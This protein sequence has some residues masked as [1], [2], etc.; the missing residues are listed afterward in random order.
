[1]VGGA[2]IAGL[3][4]KE[5]AFHVVW[6]R[7]GWECRSES[8]ALSATSELQALEILEHFSAGPRPR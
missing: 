4:Y 2:S 8:S 3:R 5:A 6:S 7:H 1:M